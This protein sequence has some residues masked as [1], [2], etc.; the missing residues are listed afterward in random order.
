VDISDLTKLREFTEL[1][2]L[3]TAL[4]HEI[5]GPLRLIKDTIR[6][7]RQKFDDPQFLKTLDT[8]DKLTASAQGLLRCLGTK[9]IGHQE[10]TCRANDVAKECAYKAEWVTGPIEA[11][12]DL[13]SL[14]P[15]VLCSSAE[16]RLVL[17][18]LVGNSIKHCNKE[19]RRDIKITIATKV[20]NGIASISVEDNCGG[21]PENIL[22]IFSDGGQEMYEMFLRSALS[23]ERA[24]NPA[25][26]P[27]RG[28]LLVK[29]IVSGFPKGSFR[30]F[31]PSS[32]SA[33]AVITIAIKR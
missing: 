32:G 27:H 11:G 10:V 9:S 3:G 33:N 8:I 17:E 4:E 5:S 25:Q 16:L 6:Y 31:N 19:D 14:D 29:L 28:L 24:L 13:D 15:E 12:L 30:I 18:N 26:E 20:K 22:E 7:S 1:A 21:Y 2:L 23:R